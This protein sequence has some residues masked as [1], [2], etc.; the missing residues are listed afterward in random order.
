[1]PVIDHLLASGFVR[2]AIWK[3]WYPFVTRRVRGEEVLF[4]NYA[5]EEVPPRALALDPADEPNRACIQ[6]YRHVATQTELRGK[7]VL[8]VS[9]GHGGG[10]SWLM[11]TQRPASYVGLDLNPAGIAFCR[12]RHRVDGLTFVQGDAENLP[13][14]DATFDAV[15]NVE[16]SHCYP[17]FPRFLTEV[18]RVLRPGGALLYADFRFTQGIAAWERDL[19]AAPLTLRATRV[20][21]AEVLRGLTRNSTRSTALIVRHLPTWLHGLG[22]DFAGIAGSRV[23]AAL[24]RGDLSYRS[25]LFTKSP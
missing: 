6:L 8:E 13:L 12:G 1:M 3:F 19:A 5:F 7:N 22:R 10:A 18:A 25:Y 2:R 20:I 14:A 23:Y 17:H 24:E 11:R 9:C 16:A 21:N 4:L 15:L